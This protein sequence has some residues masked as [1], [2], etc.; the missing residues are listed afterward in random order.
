MMLFAPDVPDRY[1]AVLSETEPPVMP[2]SSRV[3]EGFPAMMVA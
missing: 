3:E 1:P 2:F